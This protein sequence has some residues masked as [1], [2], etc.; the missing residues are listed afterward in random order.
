[1]KVDEKSYL[2]LKML[3]IWAEKTLLVPILQ[4]CPGRLVRGHPGVSGFQRGGA[5]LSLQII[6]EESPMTLIT[7][8]GPSSGSPLQSSLG[9]GGG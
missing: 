3:D 2:M 8:S 1:M 7:G 5:V 4:S 6:N 9:P